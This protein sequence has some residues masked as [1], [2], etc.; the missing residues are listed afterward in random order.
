MREECKEISQNEVE[1]EREDNTG[2][3]A[4]GATLPLMG[5]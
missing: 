1:E 5:L 4:T 2:L 3:E